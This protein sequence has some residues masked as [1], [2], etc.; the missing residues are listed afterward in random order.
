MVT[1]EYLF[2]V[3]VV[4]LE[5]SHIFINIVEET[6]RTCWL[7]GH[8]ISQINNYPT[9]AGSG[10]FDMNGID[11]LRNFFIGSCWK[12]QLAFGRMVRSLV[13][14]LVE[15]DLAQITI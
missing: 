3:F 4:S 6:V 15:K 2:T 5:S 7:P 9:P 13:L 14:H 11:F 8:G 10:E 1:N 12:V